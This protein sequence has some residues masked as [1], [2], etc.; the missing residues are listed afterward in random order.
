[1]VLLNRSKQKSDPASLETW[2]EGFLALKTCL[3]EMYLLNSEEYRLFK[4]HNPTTHKDFH[5]YKGFD[6]LEYLVKV[7]SGLESPILGETEVFGQFRQ[8]VLPFAQDKKDLFP[9]IQFALNLVKSIRTRHLVGSGSQSYGSLVRRLVKG[10]NHVLFL[11]AGILA[12]SIYPWV[13]SSKNVMFALRDKE[14][15]KKSEM[16]KEDS[17]IQTFSFE[18]NFYF[19][20]PVN[21]VICAPLTSEKIQDYLKNTRVNTVID[22]REESRQDPL[23]IDAKVYDLE[24]VFSEMKSSEEKKELIEKINNDI[25]NEIDAKFIKHRPFG[26]EDLCL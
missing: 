11:G 3:R 12:E 24:N 16:Y 20:F 26:W 6:A 14:K 17:S 18:E 15:F 25:I 2:S 5:I 9:S 4:K 1:M 7:L 8:Q 21:I 22:L 23:K 13:K 10:E 19:D